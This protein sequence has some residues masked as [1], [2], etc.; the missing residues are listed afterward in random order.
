MGQLAITIQNKCCCNNSESKGGYLQFDQDFQQIQI[1]QEFFNQQQWYIKEDNKLLFNPDKF[2][3]LYTGYKKDHDDMSKHWEKLDLRQTIKHGIFQR[4]NNYE[5]L[6]LK[7]KYLIRKGVPMNLM[8]TIILD[9]YKRTFTDN[10]QEYT[11]ALNIIFKDNIPSQIK[12]APLLMDDDRPIE[13]VVKFSILN[14]K[15]YEALKRILWVL[16]EMYHQIDYNPMVV[17][18]AALLLVFLKE[19]E[20]YAVLKLMIEDSTKLL[21]E[22]KQ[23]SSAEEERS[24]R[25]HFLMKKADFTRFAKSFFDTVSSKSKTFKQILQHFKDIGFDYLDL[26]KDITNSIFSGYLNFSTVIKIFIIY[27]NEGIKVYFRFMYALCRVI[28][29]DILKVRDISTMKS[30]IRKMGLNMKPK[31]IK[32]MINKAFSLR[33]VKVNQTLQRYSIRKSDEV[34]MA[35]KKIYFIPHLDQESNIINQEQLETIWGWLP[36]ILKLSDGVQ[37]WCSNQDGYSLANLYK[38][39]EQYQGKQ[40]LLLV[41]ACNNSVFGAYCDQILKPQNNYFGS[42]ESFVFQLEPEA[43]KFETQE[44]QTN[45]LFCCLDYFSFGADN[46]AL[47][48]DSSLSRGSTDVSKT[49]KNPVLTGDVNK[50]H[51]SCIEFEVYTFE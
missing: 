23:N 4:E 32:E 17:Q 11:I 7:W 40:M 15:G 26:F 34:E 39:C 24:L 43:V 31:Q 20:A 19:E 45:H 49:Y 37:I 10:L 29:K 16:K 47:Q 6:A 8:R 22:S 5:V 48:I 1:D 9:I 18:I 50:K 14:E 44:D 33:L 36:Q 3:F 46:A 38:R 12:T 35:T 42:F 30:L 25:W 51:F 27:M 21:S 28:Y 13:E 2:I 41:K